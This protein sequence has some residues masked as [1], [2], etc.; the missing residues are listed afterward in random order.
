[1]IK[2]FNTISPDWNIPHVKV[3]TVLASAS[4]FSLVTFNHDNPL[5]D[6]CKKN[7]EHLIQPCQPII[8]LRQVHGKRIVQVPMK[9]N[10][11][12]SSG[13]DCYLK[14]L[15]ADGVFTFNK[16]AVCAVI[17]ADCLPIAFSNRNGT[18]IGVVHAG[19]KGLQNGI[20]TEMVKS[21][22]VLPEEIFA[23]IG[24]GIAAESYRISREIREEFLAL[25]SVYETVFTDC[26]EGQYLMDLY[27]VA[28]IQLEIN[29]FKKEHVSGGTW[30]T[31]SDKRFHSAR[32]DNGQSGRMATL[33][34][35]E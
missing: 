19:R 4:D 22:K 6:Q 35:M 30:D 25:S 17:T 7:I 27:Q 5:G 15:E 1:M 31:F 28:R 14:N 26:G 8:W 2:N 12:D 3:C 32:R 16:R 23:W 33:A 34:W 11:T 21:F 20:I 18:Q 9:E 24:P 29:G 10:I 13:N